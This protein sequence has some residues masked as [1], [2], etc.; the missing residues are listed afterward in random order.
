MS[1]S[2]PLA[3]D[4]DIEDES[5]D[6]RFRRLVRRE[7][8]KF[9]FRPKII[10]V[11]SIAINVAF[12]VAFLVF[13]LSWKHTCT[14]GDSETESNHSPFVPPGIND[15]VLLP[16]QYGWQY[17]ADTVEDMEKV[18]RNWDALN[19]DIGW[20]SMPQAELSRWGYRPGSD[21]P[22]DPSMGVHTLQ[23]YHSMHCLKII[24]HT[25]LQLARGEELNIRFGHSMH[26][27]GSLL[28]DV[29]CSADDS[30]PLNIPGNDDG[31]Y[32]YV[33]KCRN[34]GALSRWA[35]SRTS[36]MITN[37]EGTLDQ[38]HQYLANC[39]RTDG[40]IIPT[41]NKGPV[42]GSERP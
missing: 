25:M 26:C 37:K 6:T 21:N 18:D 19:P 10:M 32:Q 27:L 13:L 24:R 39:T 2:T 1:E 3:L 36:C 14:W 12:S 35:A 16:I 15:E 28:R 34:W 41:L 20:I 31:R 11:V 17:Y 33:R 7:R 30:L 8:A 23:G 9:D 22:S 38:E 5:M 40:V 42:S 4:L 29:I